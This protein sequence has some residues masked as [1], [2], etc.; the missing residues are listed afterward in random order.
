M[1]MCVMNWHDSDRCRRAHEWHT[2]QTRSCE[3]WKHWLCSTAGG[4]VEGHKWKSS[5]WLWTTLNNYRNVL[6]EKLRTFFYSCRLWWLKEKM[7]SPI[8]EVIFITIE[9]SNKQIESSC[10]FIRQILINRQ[11]L[12]ML[13]FYFK[14]VWSLLS[15]RK[16]LR[17]KT[18]TESQTFRRHAAHELLEF[19]LMIAEGC[20][21]ATKTGS[22]T[23]F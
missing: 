17:W 15:Y 19:L 7:V 21:N 22:A 4:V 1:S 16:Q 9:E 2:A 20:V 5:S 23:L 13:L 10:D 3:A 6:H 14:W 8:K 11:G 12:R 18:R